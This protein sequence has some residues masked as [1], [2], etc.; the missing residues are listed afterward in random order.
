MKTF[1]EIYDRAAKRKGGEAELEKL[2]QVDL[3]TPKQLAAI[4]DDRYL[5][6]MT[7][8]VFKAGFVWRVIENKWDGF[9]QA[10]WQFN[11]TRCAYMSEEDIDTLAKDERIVRNRQKILTVREN[12]TFLLDIEKEH[13]GFGKFIGDWP[14]ADYVDLLELLKKRGSRL[15]GVS[16]QYFLRRMG[17][18][19]FVMG[20]DGV[21]AL[22]DA[23]VVD[24]NPTSKTAMKKVQAAYN[25][26]SAESGL[27]LAQISR[28]LSMSLDAV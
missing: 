25:D 4:S 10:F 26:W 5:S 24:K 11:V 19:G 28:V 15:G 17:K 8:A 9:E 7:D 14:D 13:G 23:G 3:K 20:R 27:N 6:A 2:I 22:I 1:A 16:A 18:A 21:A 12:A